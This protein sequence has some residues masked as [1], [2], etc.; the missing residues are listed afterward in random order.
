MLSPEELLYRCVEAVN[1]T[2]APLNAQMDIKLR[3]LICLG[4]SKSPLN[5][6]GFMKTCY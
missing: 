6:A 1:F 3:S 5:L 4:N 2:H